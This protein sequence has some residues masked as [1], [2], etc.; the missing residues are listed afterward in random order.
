MAKH[1]LVIEDMKYLREIQVLLLAEAGYTATGFEDAGEALA[2]LPDLAPDLIVLDL[3][4]PGMDGRQ[5]LARL[6]A[7]AAW[8]RLPVLISTGRRPDDLAFGEHLDLLS[9]PFTDESLL[10]RVRAMIGSA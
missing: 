5:F 1:I 6:R 4:L 7:T 8:A 10:T 3:G 9:K 2:R